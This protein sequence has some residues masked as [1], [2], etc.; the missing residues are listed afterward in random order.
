[1]VVRIAQSGEDKMASHS[2]QVD[3]RPIN[4]FLFEFNYMQKP[5]TPNASASAPADAHGVA[6]RIA[7]PKIG[8]KS[9]VVVAKNDDRNG[10]MRCR[11]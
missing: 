10:S 11:S 1:M 3:G 4:S 6:A 8:E 7:T 5:W 9:A 2:L